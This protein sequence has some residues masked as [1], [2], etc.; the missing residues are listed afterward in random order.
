MKGVVRSEMERVLRSFDQESM[1]LWACD[2]FGEA[3][4]PPNKQCITSKER[5]NII[6]EIENMPEKDRE[7]ELSKRIWEKSC[8]VCRLFG[9]PW[10]ASRLAFK[11]ASLTN[12]QDLMDVTSVRDGVGIDRD[13]GA[14]KDGIKY[15]FEVV[16][17]GAKFSI[18]ILAENVDAWEIGLLLSMLRPW[19][20]GYLPIGGKS[21]RGPGWGK[22]TEISIQRIEKKDLL[23][24]LL[25]AK[26]ESVPSETFVQSFRDHLSQGGVQNA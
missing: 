9:S 14:A 11:D 13:R 18:S 7:A 1:K 17:P 5:D 21:S 15:D 3:I 4:D 2:P 16:S 23:D 6:K 20:E 12:L 24:Y 22:L 10:L 19:Q 26:M 8:T 25:G